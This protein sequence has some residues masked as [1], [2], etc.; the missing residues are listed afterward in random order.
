MSQKPRER[1]FQKAGRVNH[2]KKTRYGL[3]GVLWTL[4]VDDTQSVE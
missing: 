1:V 4:K 3:K 2:I